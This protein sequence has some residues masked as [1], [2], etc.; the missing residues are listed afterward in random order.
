MLKILSGCRSSR[1]L[2]AFVRRD[3]EVLNET[4]GLDCRR[5]HSSH[6]PLAAQQAQSPGVRGCA[7]GLNI[8]QFPGEPT[9]LDQ[10]VCVASGSG[11][12]VGR[13]LLGSAFVTEETNHRLSES[14]LFWRELLSGLK[15]HGLTRVRLMVSDAHVGLTKAVGQMFQG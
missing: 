9:G 13:T 12:A 11:E 5:W 7:P 4:L 15:Q 2:E 6:L 14:E 3:R 10:L 1:D 8:N